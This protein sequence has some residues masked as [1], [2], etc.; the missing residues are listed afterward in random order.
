MIR[1]ATLALSLVLSVA[2]T[3]PTQVLVRADEVIE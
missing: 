3:I 2:F 1:N